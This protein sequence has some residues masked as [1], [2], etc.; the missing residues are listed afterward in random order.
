MRYRFG[1]S[2]F[3]GLKKHKTKKNANIFH[4][5]KLEGSQS[6]NSS[7]RLCLLNVPRKCQ[8]RGAWALI[9]F[10]VPNFCHLKQQFGL[11][12]DQK[13]FFQTT[14]VSFHGFGTAVSVLWKESE[15]RDKKPSAE[16]NF[17]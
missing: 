4:C 16:R 10:G 13:M 14:G 5:F 17:E 15:T 11:L 8:P 2:P 12:R 9:S 7:A 6:S 3:L 1:F